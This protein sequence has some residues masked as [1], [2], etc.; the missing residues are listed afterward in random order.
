MRSVSKEAYLF[1][2]GEEIWRFLEAVWLVSSQLPQ[3]LLSFFF[4]FL[5]HH[6]ACESLVPQPGINP[7]PSALEALTT[8]L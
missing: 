5:L 7:V 8:A 3:A 1:L 4:F 2:K 6:A